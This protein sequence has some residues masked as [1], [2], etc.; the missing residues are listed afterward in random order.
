MNVLRFNLK[1]LLFLLALIAVFSFSSV[2]AQEDAEAAQ[3]E[4]LDRVAAE[5]LTQGNAAVLEEFIAD[6]YVVH[7]PFGD[8]NRD[9][10]KGLFDALRA[11]MTDFS[12]TREAMIVEGNMAGMRTI[13][14]GTFENEFNGPF[15]VFPPTDQPFHLE[16]INLFRFNDAGT[17]QEEWAQ[18]DTAAFMGQLGA[19]PAPAAQGVLSEEAAAHFAERLAAIFD[20]PNLDIADEIFAPDFVAHLPLA[21]E[22]DL[23][24]WKGYVASFYVG[25]PD[26]T[27]QVN[28]IIIAPDRLILHS[29]YSGTHTGE[30]F[31]IPATGNPVSLNGIT[32]FRFNDEGLASEAWSVIDVVGLLAQI[33]AFPPAPA[34]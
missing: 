14:N 28:Q 1:Q 7:S 16:I 30:L 22:L 6:D 20:G 18:F 29:T 12:V 24:N 4:A 9:A 27:D 21:P 19:A 23:E 34:A 15:G 10:V 8:L 11:A 31:G 26:L 33:G 2:Y 3:R 13:L 17:I 25:I 32:I 5:G